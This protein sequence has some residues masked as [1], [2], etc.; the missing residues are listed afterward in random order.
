MR[1][2]VAEQVVDEAEEPEPEDR[3]EHLA[4]GHREAGVVADTQ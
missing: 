3:E 2:A 1:R 4:A